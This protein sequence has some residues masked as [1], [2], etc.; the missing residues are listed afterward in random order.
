[1]Q[2][3]HKLVVQL[4]EQ[5]S[6]INVI[7]VRKICRCTLKILIFP[8]FFQR[9]KF[10]LTRSEILNFFCSSPITS[11]WPNSQ[12]FTTCGGMKVH[13]S[14]R[15]FFY[16]HSQSIPVHAHVVKNE[17]I[18]SLFLLNHSSYFISHVRFFSDK[19]QKASPS[20]SGQGLS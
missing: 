19:N 12:S 16:S 10:S 20:S 7:H 13:D 2:T 3:P 17:L 18:R 4:H 1:M 15:R 8:D 5:Y 14:L 9:L 11:L 6:T